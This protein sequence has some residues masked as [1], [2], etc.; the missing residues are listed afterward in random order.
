ME[1]KG[2]F[3]SVS[4]LALLGIVQGFQ[5]DQK[6]QPER[7]EVTVRLILVDVIATDKQDQ[8][9][10]GLTIEDF[11]VYEDGKRIPLNSV[12]FINFQRQAQVL[13]GR[14]EAVVRKKR[15]FVVF[16]SINTVKRMLDRSKVRILERLITLVQSGGEI[17][18]FDLSQKGGIQV[19]QPFTSNPQLIAQAIEKAR[20]F[21]HNTCSDEIKLDK[22]HYRLIFT[23][24]DEE[25]GRVGTV[26]QVLDAPLLKERSKPEIVN[27]VFGLMRESQETTRS[28]KIS[29]KDGTM[30]MERYKFYPMGS[31]QFRGKETVSL[32]LQVITPNK[33]SVYKTEMFLFQQNQIVG[34]VPVKIFKQQRNKKANIMNIVYSLDFGQFFRGKY[35]LQI[36]LH[37]SLTNEE[38]AKNVQIQIL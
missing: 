27:A 24:Y 1:K 21:G 2:V 34:H 15:F 3:L 33:D 9:V 29:Q 18:V 17:M 19:L 4:F 20:Y 23:L 22:D 38:I 5:K 36:K 37:D 11:E 25:S 8:V 28:F 6:I 26:E 16:D 30:G 31:N 35:T 10:T 14:E 12:D 13:A 32:L 7:H